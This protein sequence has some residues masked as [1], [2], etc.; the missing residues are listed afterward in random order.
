VLAIGGERLTRER[1]TNLMSSFRPGEKTRLTVSR[2]DRIISLDIKLDTAVPEIYTIVPKP[3]FDKRDVARLR[4]L[5]GQDP[6]KQ[7]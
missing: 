1:L 4:S 5:L 7:P 3:G 2:R 6:S